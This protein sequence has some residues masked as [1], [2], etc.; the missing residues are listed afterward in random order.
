MQIVKKR[1]D[2]LKPLEKNVRKH[3]EIQIK[4]FARSIQQFG[5]VRAFVI[6][7]Q[8]N[9]LIGNGMYEAMKVLGKTECDCHVMTGLSEI[10][11]KKLIISDN[12]I[13]ELGVDDYAIT[14]EFLQEIVKSGDTDVAG[15]DPDVLSG[16]VNLTH[17]AEVKNQEYGVVNPA[18]FAEVI[19]PQQT[20]PVAPVQAQPTV[21]VTESA[22]TA[23]AHK[24]IVCPHCGERIEL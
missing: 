6:D 21:Q 22:P 12:K 5:Q 7:E 13:F 14:D 20:Q 15:F 16:I 24:Y 3:T 2:E 23:E 9:I 8:N 10:D 1:L 19:I 18:D 11:K 17:T 4:E